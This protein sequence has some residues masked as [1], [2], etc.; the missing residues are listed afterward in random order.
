MNGKGKDRRRLAA[1]PA[2]HI[3]SLMRRW[4]WAVLIGTMAVAP[5]APA[6]ADQ[7]DAR[8]NGLFTGLHATQSP[9][10]AKLLENSIWEIW[11]ESPDPGT[12]RLMEQGLTAMAEDEAQAALAAFD[13]VVK[14]SSGFAEG[15]NKRATVEYLLG[16]YDASVA[17]IMRTLQLEP[18]HFGALSGLGEIYLAQGNKPAALKAFSAALAIDP[19][20]EGVKAAVATLKQEIDGN[21]I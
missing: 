9:G 2:R 4:L 21:P 11:A 17:D 6:R 13:A 1:R 10:W 12:E 3:I 18:R 7:G 8:L 5:W 14:R 19:Y 15:W 20:L 16:D